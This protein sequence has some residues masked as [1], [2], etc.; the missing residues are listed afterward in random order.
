MAVKNESICQFVNLFMH[1]TKMTGR[2]IIRFR[3]RIILKGKQ[4]VNLL[5][6][7][8]NNRIHVARAPAN[9]SLYIF[10]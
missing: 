2:I 9:D 8:C 5:S 1:Y 6:K 4:G 7:F 10:F 3:N